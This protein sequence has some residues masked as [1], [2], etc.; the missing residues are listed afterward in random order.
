MTP[1]QCWTAGWK[2]REKLEMITTICRAMKRGLCLFGLISNFN[3]V[4]HK[5]IT[6][7]LMTA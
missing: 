7:P 6:A 3:S 4:S 2:R 1:Y 5:S